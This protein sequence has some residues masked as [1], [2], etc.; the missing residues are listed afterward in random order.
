MVCLRA[1]AGAEAAGLP[2]PVKMLKI[3]CTDD[4][5]TH[6]ILEEHAR[7]AEVL[8]DVMDDRGVCAA[9]AAPPPDLLCVAAPTEGTVATTR[10]SV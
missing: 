9:C 5:S 4:G 3:V 2:V 10:T 7:Q 6:A 1:H 8:A